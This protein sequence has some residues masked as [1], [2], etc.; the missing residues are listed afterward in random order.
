MSDDQDE[1]I[2]RLKAQ[3]AAAAGRMVVHESEAMDPAVRE[4]FWRHVVAFETA[5]TTDLLKELKAVGVDVPDPDTLSDEALH[6]AL[7]VTIEALGR[8]HVYL[9]ETDHLSDRELY[10]LLWGEL[11]PEEMPALDADEGSVWHLD[12]LG[13]CSEEDIALRLKHYADEAERDRTGDP[14]FPT[15][16]CPIT[17]IRRTTAIAIYRRTTNGRLDDLSAGN[18]APSEI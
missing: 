3:A 13:G 11:L 6:A 12:I 17:W 9:D 4:A 1:I 18:L 8:M 14:V 2:E 15:T 5:G 10:T 7:W 16:C